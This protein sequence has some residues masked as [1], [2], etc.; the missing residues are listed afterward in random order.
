MD[1]KGCLMRSQLKMR[2]ILEAEGKTVLV[3]KMAKNLAKLCF[4]ESRV[5]KGGIGYLAELISKQSVEQVDSFLLT[6]YSKN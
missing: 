5:F 1:I 2:N 4:V 6:A 3:R